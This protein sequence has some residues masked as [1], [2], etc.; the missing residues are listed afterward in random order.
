MNN[1]ECLS[2]YTKEELINLIEIYSKNWLALDGV[3]FQSIERK[4]G[5]DE[6]M[7]YDREAWRRFT[8]IEAKR[9]KEFLGLGNN[10]GIEGLSKA[11]RLRFNS[12]INKDKIEIGKNVLIY[13]VLDCRVQ[14]A[15]KRKCMP[16][17]PCKS[18][19][20]IEYDGFAKTID[21]RFI[22]ECE[23]C[24]PDISDNDCACKWKFVL[25]EK[26]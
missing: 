19:G 3:W 7:F 26:K 20:I 24:Y 14:S 5:M 17:H 6:A 1:Y 11:L 18:V 22:C 8:V 25:K 10:S 21:E 15:R 9:I 2:S 23:S 16:L 13:S 4:F 12:N